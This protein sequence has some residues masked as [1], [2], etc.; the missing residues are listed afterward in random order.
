MINLN[1]WRTLHLKGVGKK[2]EKSSK[3]ILDSQVKNTYQFISF[4]D[5]NWH[6]K[7]FE[8]LS[9]KILLPSYGSTISRYKLTN[10]ASQG[11]RKQNKTQTTS[12]NIIVQ[13][14][15]YKKATKERS[16]NSS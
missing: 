5:E 4:T 14:L 9:L 8:Q 10:D 3:Q 6:S 16:V 1:Q 2:K 11:K 15:F 7:P 12:I 13:S